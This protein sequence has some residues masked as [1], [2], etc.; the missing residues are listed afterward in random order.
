MRVLPIPGFPQYKVDEEGN[1]YGPTKTEPMK[2]TANHGGY[3]RVTLRKDCESFTRSVHVLV[4]LA[5]VGPRPDRF[6]GCHNDGDKA[7]NRLSNLRWGSPEENEKDKTA[8]GTKAIGRRNGAVRLTVEQVSEI[9]IAKASG[10]RVWGCKALARK[11]GV[12]RATVSD[13]ADRLNWKHI[14]M[15]LDAA[16]AAQG[17]AA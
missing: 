1:V 7:N 11:F 3:F 12:D 16:R 10:N 4:L 13:V 6:L 2:Q 14:P 5:F 15:E 17:G 9:R 8:H